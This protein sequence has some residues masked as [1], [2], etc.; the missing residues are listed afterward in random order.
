MENQEK[1][2]IDIGIICRRVMEKKKLFFIILPIVFI[3][4]CLYIICIPRYY[5]SEVKL[6]PESDNGFSGNL[7]TLGSLASTFGVDLTDMQSSDAISPTLYPDL[8]DDNGFVAEL[9]PIH[10]ESSEKSEDPPIST[11]YY[12]YLENHQK[13]AWWNGPIKWIKEKMSFG[14]KDEDSNAKKEINPYALSRKQFKIVEALRNNINIRSDKKTGVLTIAVTSQD[15]L[16]SKTMA[17][18]I[19]E[20]LQEYITDY[21]TSKSR[22]DLEHYLKLEAQAKKNYEAA[23]LKYSKFS[24]AHTDVVLASYQVT[25]DDL[26]NDMQ[27]KYNTYSS[28]QTQVQVARAK[29]QARTPAFTVLKGAEVPVKPAGPKRMIFVFIMV[30]LA[31]TATLLYII[32]DDLR[33]TLNA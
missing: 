30:F 28:L 6:V 24:D 27:L 8:M 32:R 25:R 5:T 23:R 14:K 19:K 31:F 15:P 9:F 13:K 2:T 17:D 26:E 1:R 16:I 22:I 3:L 18:S 4:S 20:R 33:Q 29:V 11:T 7:G 12:D 10:V 21:R